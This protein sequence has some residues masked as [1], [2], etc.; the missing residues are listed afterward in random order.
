[1]KEQYGRKR[2]VVGSHYGVY[3]F[4]IQR[5]TALIIA[6]YALVFL[7]VLLI[8]P[9]SY[10]TWKSMF[11]WSIMGYPT[12]QLLTTAAF[13]AMAWHAFI[14]VRDI[15]MDYIKPAGLR[16]LCHVGAI[17]WLALSVIYFVQVIWSVS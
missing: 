12:G 3:G 9:A 8:R 4:I 14:G 15:F 1:M 6:T 2:T 5:F 11:V 10:E 17:V 7:T 13:I 16:L